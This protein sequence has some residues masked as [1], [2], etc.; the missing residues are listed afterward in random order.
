MYEPDPELIRAAGAGDTAAFEELV[1]A[2]QSHVWRFL[3]HLLGDPA[4]A[5]DITQETFVRVYRKLE[6]FR[7]RSK[8]STWVFSVARNAGIDALRSR[9]RREQLLTVV[10]QRTRDSVAGIELGL[11][12]EAALQSLS[13]KLREAFVMIEALGL[14]YREAGGAL[15]VAEGTVKSRVFHAREQLVVWMSAGEGTADET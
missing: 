5:E 1:R 6:T 14:T 15:G 3:R 13:P 9:Q 2:Y 8:F 10:A 4:L 11:E 7:F 12:I